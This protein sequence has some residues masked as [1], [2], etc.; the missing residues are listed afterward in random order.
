ML[1]VTRGS[2]RGMTSIHLAS[3]AWLGSVVFIFPGVLFL[4]VDREYVLDV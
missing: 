3:G 4:R 1:G 2:A